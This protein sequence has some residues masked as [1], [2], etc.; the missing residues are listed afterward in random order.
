MISIGNS[1]P[2]AMQAAQLEPPI[3]DRRLAGREKSPHPLEVRFA[4]RRRDDRLGEVAADRLLARPAERLFRLCVP[5]D[6]AAVGVHA[7]E[8]VVRGVEDQV[9]AG[10][11]L[12]HLAERFAPPF[13]GDRH[14]DQV[15]GGDREVLFVN[16]PRARP[17]DVLDA[18][19][20]DHVLAAAQRHVEHGLDVERLEVRGLEFAGPRIGAGIGG[21]DHAFALDGV[22]ICRRRVARRGPRR[23]RARFRRAGTIRRRRCSPA[24]S[25]KR[26]RL[27]RS[28]SSVAAAISRMPRRRCSKVSFGSAWL[29]VSDVSAAALLREALFAVFEC[30][31]R[32]QL[33]ADVFDHRQHGRL[34]VPGDHPRRGA[35]PERLAVG[36]P[37]VQQHIV[38]L[39]GL[40][41]RPRRRSRCERSA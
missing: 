19:H 8:R 23:T 25:P 37:Q 29:A 15:G 35:R 3:D 6:D 2:F 7:D 13:V 9:G 14:R 28:T 24:R 39:P 36:L 5:A 16:R 31:L 22:E 30:V 34:V 18:Q 21:G 10:V 4:E 27:T 1:W 17:A 33:I 41:E 11:A 12:R 20:A 38:G 26:H 40:L 32:R